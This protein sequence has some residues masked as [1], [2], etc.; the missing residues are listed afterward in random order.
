MGVGQWLKVAADCKAE[1]I[2]SSLDRRPC[3]RSEACAEFG[4]FV[5]YTAIRLARWLN[6]PHLLPPGRSVSLEV[7]VVHALLTRHHLSLCGLNT[8]T[9]VW[10]GQALD[11]VP[12]FT[13]DL[14]APSLALAFMDHRGTRFHSDLSLL[15]QH[16][17]LLPGFTHICD[18]T[19]KPGAPLCLWVVTYRLGGATATSWSMNEF[20]HSN[21]EDW[22]LVSGHDQGCCVSGVHPAPLAEL[23]SF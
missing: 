6:A 9:D 19:L 14:G 11:L 4:T 23:C 8:I 7:D 15:E 5:G 21:S 3:Q 12:R 10:V 17:V 16:G 18:N 22:M 1:L 2:D 20:A 13:E